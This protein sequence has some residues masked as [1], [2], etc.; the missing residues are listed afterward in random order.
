MRPQGF[1]DERADRVQDA[2]HGIKDGTKDNL[3]VWVVVDGGLDRFEISV[4]HIAP[5][6]VVQR[7]RDLVEV[8]RG[9]GLLERRDRFI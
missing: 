4:S 8:V 7:V 6:E 2:Q 1:A 9:K 5:Y 3:L